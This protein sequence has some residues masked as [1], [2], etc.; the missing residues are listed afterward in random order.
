MKKKAYVREKN[1]GKPTPPNSLTRVQYL[2]FGYLKIFV[3]TME[4]SKVK[5]IAISPKN[6]SGKS[7]KIINMQPGHLTEFCLR[8]INHPKGLSR[9]YH[10]MPVLPGILLQNCISFFF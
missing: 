3:E 7:L 1:H 8:K 6:A 2:H 4:K 9:Q 10:K 5:T